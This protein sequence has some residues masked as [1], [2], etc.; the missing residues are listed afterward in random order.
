M[1]IWDILGGG[2]LLARLDNHQKT[3]T[4]L[5]VAAHAGPASSAAPRLLT[6][7]LDTHV[8]VSAVLGAAAP[9]ERNHQSPDLMLLSPGASLPLQRPGCQ[10]GCHTFCSCRTRSTV[11]L[12]A[13]ICCLYCCE[14][15]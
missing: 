14:I 5:R 8:K 10:Q 9:P 11:C 3:V 6:G 7:S 2:R 1:C 4:C 12:H 15:A 13:C